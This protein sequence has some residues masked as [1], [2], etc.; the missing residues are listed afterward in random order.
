[1]E[2]AEE[3]TQKAKRNNFPWTVAREFTLVNYVFKEKGHLRTDVNLND[4]FNAISRKIV[5][6][7][8]FPTESSLDGAALK[9]K[10][11]RLAAAADAKYAISEEGANLS[12]LEE[13]GT[14][15]EKLILSM[16]REKFETARAKDEQ[17]AKDT[18]RNEKM[19]T[20]ERTMLAR[21]DKRERDVQSDELSDCSGSTDNRSKKSKTSHSK[22]PPEFDFE[23]EVLNSLKEDPRIIELEIAERKQKMENEIADRAFSRE[24]EL[25]RAEAE[26]RNAYERTRADVERCKADVATANMQKMMLEFL[27]KHMNK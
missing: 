2:V 22:S 26:E 25:R 27:Y 24:M 19:L 21:Q 7:Q 17:K 12:H 20:H 6:D 3:R 9:K 10:W 11:E 13:D 1:M 18:E 16:L 15:T 8:A 4:K 14:Q 5:A 23:K